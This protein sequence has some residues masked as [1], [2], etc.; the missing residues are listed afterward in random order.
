M[1]TTKNHVFALKVTANEHLWERSKTGSQGVDKQST[2][3]AQK[4]FNF[5]FIPDNE[6]Q[7]IGLFSEPL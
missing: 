6:T 5:F 3:C 7:Q 1:Y 4:Q 2:F